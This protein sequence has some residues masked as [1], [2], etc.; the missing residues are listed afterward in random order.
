MRGLS[1]R[2]ALGRLRPGGRPRLLPSL[3]GLAPLDHAALPLSR[4]RGRGKALR[5]GSPS[6]LAHVRGAQ[7]GHVC[8]P[9]WAT[10]PGD[11]AAAPDLTLAPR[12]PFGLHYP[13]V[14]GSHSAIPR[15]GGG[16][17]DRRAAWGLGD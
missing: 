8:A 2:A 1:G 7:K 16:Q 14:R 11:A 13:H 17:K 6:A 10:A 3:R 9:R 5:G 15:G 4:G 12:K